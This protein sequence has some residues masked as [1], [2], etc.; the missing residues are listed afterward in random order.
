MWVDG[1]VFG[2]RLG[3]LVAVGESSGTASLSVCRLAL[4]AETD[5]GLPHEQYSEDEHGDCE[6]GTSPKAGSL[7]AAPCRARPNT[8]VSETQSIAFDS[9][10]LMTET[11]PVLRFVSSGLRW[12]RGYR[13]ARLGRQVPIAGRAVE[14]TKRSPRGFPRRTRMTKLRI[15]AV[16]GLLSVATIGISALVAGPIGVPLPPPPVLCGCA[17]PDGSFVTTHAPDPGS[18]ESACAAACD[19]GTF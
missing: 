10:G 16:V 19:S 2:G 12:G 1:L 15:A 14:W 3:G 13:C 18:C 9:A 7:Q 6:A 8:H 4:A 5:V 11:A 17:C